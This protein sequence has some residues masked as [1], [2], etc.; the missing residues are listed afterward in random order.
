[1]ILIRLLPVILIA[2]AC[3]RDI[4]PSDKPPTQVVLQ[5][6]RLKE[7][8]GIAASVVNP[9][10][11]YVHNDSGDSSRWFAISPDGGLKSVCYFNGNPHL[12]LGVVDVEDIAVC[13]GP[14]SGAHYVYLGDIGDND[15]AR[16]NIV[17]YRVKEPVLSASGDYIKVNADPLVLRYPDG[18]RDAETLLADPVEKLLYVVSKREDS[19]SVYSTPLNFK[20]HDTLVLTL[21]A[22]LF[23]AGSG[24]T[25]WITAGDISAS[26]S[27]ILLKSYTQV[28]YW[29]RDAGE[30]V[31]QALQR[32]PTVLPYVIEPQGEAIGFTVDGKGYYTVSEGVNPT[33]YYY[34][35]LR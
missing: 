8:S 26:G 6:S 17:I 1:M 24:K 14:E 16:E 5:D 34:E 10:I 11:L 23:F 35:G 20:A 29:Q 30:S 32:K 13:T 27:R 15:A 21:R 25:K 18:P 9:G 33:L 28:F 22:K 2:I 12:G 3:K 7:L 4:T 31:W 19:V